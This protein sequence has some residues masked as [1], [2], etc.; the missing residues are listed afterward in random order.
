MLRIRLYIITFGIVCSERFRIFYTSLISLRAENEADCIFSS[1][2][3][4]F[5]DIKFKRACFFQFANQILC[6]TGERILRIRIG[7]GNMYRYLLCFRIA[8][9]E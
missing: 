8:E 2:T 7:S 1:I 6:Y 9:K 5:I 3:P 4:T